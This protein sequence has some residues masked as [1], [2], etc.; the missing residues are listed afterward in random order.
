MGQWK[1]DIKDTVLRRWDAEVGGWGR[2]GSR[3]EGREK[4]SQL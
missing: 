1:G 3:R 2:G 4:V